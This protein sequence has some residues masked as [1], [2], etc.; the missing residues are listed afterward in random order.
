MMPCP[1]MSR[2]SHVFFYYPNYDAK[3]APLNVMASTATTTNTHKV[4]SGAAI[5]QD[6]SLLSNQQSGRTVRIGDAVDEA[7]K[8]LG[9][10]SPLSS[11][12]GE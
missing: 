3:I 11:F 7:A 4:V 6:Y 2:Y 9:D 12:I 8:K 5:V 1:W 10:V